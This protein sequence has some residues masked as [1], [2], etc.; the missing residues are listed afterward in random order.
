MCGI[1]GYIG[2]KQT[3]FILI[4]GLKRMEYRGYDSAGLAL[5]GKK[6]KENIL[7]VVK[8]PGRVSDL[9]S[10]KSEFQKSYQGIAH[11]RWATHG[12]P[13]EVN[14]HPQIDCHG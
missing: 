10:Q 3:D 12:E 4:Q 2:Q 13:S 5:V 7:Q 6:D 8:Q 1:I 14:A 11:T 9:E